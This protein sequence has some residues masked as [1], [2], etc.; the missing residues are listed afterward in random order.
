MTLDADVLVDRRRLRRSASFWRALA[1]IAIAATV[2]AVAIAFGVGDGLVGKNTPHIARLPIEG[3][4]TDDRRTVEMIE[5]L[6]DNDA[7]KA[8]ILYVNSPGGSTT[9][10][11]V[12]YNA[13]RELAEKKPLVAQIGTL[14]ASAGYLIALASD[15][16][17]AHRT[18]LTGSIGVLMQYGQVYE[19][20]DSLGIQVDTVQSGPLKAEPSPF[21][22]PPQA[23]IDM[24][25]G[26]IGDSY[27]WFLGLVVERRNMDDA[28]AR[29]LADGR[30]FT[31]HQALEAKLIDALGGERAAVDWLS[32]EK[33]IDPELPVRTWSLE[34]DLEDL[35]FSARIAHGIT[36]GVLTATGLD[37]ALPLNIGGGGQLDGLVS[38]WHGPSVPDTGGR[39][40]RAQ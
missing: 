40:G 20:L 16:I 36:H 1:V 15:H 26:I 22:E 5:D 4:I 10:G 25:Q 35:P 3:V 21:S 23:A 33:S 8:V 31:G 18:S 39:Q 30:V 13:L 12:T 28:T 29:G 38:L 2:A 32:S 27:D 37:R 7:V 19:M 9:G 11:E 24:L 14:G 34:N 17:V 6:T